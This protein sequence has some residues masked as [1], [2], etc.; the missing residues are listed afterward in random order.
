MVYF[1]GTMRTSDTWY[2]TG[3]QP[4]IWYTVGVDNLGQESRTGGNAWTSS[5]DHNDT[6]AYVRRLIEMDK[7]TIP[8]DGGEQFNRLIFAGE[9][10]SA[11]ACGKPGGLVSRGETRHLQRP[12]AEDKPVFL[13]I[14]YAT[15]HWCHVMAH[16]SFEDQE[17]AEVL[18]RHFISIKV[19]REERPDIDDQYMTVSQLMTGSGGW[20]LN[21]FMTPDKR[22]FFTVTYLP[23]TA[24]MGMPGIIELLENIAELWKTGRDRVE[25]NCADVM[26]SLRQ[27]AVPVSGK[28]PETDLFDTAFRQLDAMYDAEWGGFG[29]APKFPMPTNLAFLLRFWKR[30]GNPRRSCHGGAHAADDAARRHLGPDRLRLPPLCR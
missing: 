3:A 7:S 27:T 1:S 2:L 25:K 30:S 22:P 11:A 28:L 14:G 29:S 19:D 12:E 8:P 24:R 5:R 10:L 23:K 4:I 18:N 26:E 20:P 17:V 21:V 15:C 9:S 6:G 13:S 16:E